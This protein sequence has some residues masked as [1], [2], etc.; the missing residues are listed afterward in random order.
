MNAATLFRQA[1]AIDDTDPRRATVLY[2]RALM[3]DPTL[4][5]AMTNLG[6]VLYL[7]GRRQ[8]ARRWWDRAL[9]VNPRQVDAIYNVGH[10]LMEDKKFFAAMPYFEDAVALDP[11]CANASQGT[12]PSWWERLRALGAIRRSTS[13]RKP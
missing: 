3:L 11:S 9:E 7:A 6:R 4:D 1:C 10:M 12:R 13:P 5:S 8:E 2:R